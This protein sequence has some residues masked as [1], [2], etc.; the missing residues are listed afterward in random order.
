MVRRNRACVLVIALNSLQ[1][2]RA[3]DDKTTT[4][5]STST[6][7]LSTIGWKPGQLKNCTEPGRKLIHFSQLH[8]ADENNAHQRGFPFFFSLNNSSL[9]ELIERRRMRSVT[10]VDLPFFSFS[11][12]WI[13]WRSFYTIATTTCKTIRV[14]LGSI[15]SDW[16]FLGDSLGSDSLT[17]HRLSLHFHCHCARRRWLFH[18]C[19][20]QT[21]CRKRIEEEEEES[22]IDAFVVATRTGWRCCRCDVHGSWILFSWII[23]S[24]HW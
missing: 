7:G 20:G 17:F 4:I 15:V 5:I 9:I 2:D 16:C 8:D 12:R 3:D 22:S 1:L 18:F 6:V 14:K 21:L 11:Y 23:H 19:S 10:P 24:R 13:S